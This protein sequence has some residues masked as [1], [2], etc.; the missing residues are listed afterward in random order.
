MTILFLVHSGVRYVWGTRGTAN[1][2]SLGGGAHKSESHVRFTK[3]TRA[4]C[5]RVGWGGQ[6]VAGGGLWVDIFWPLSE[7]D[8]RA[9]TTS[10]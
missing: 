4:V 5:R 1:R 10:A 8:H 7:W 9:I 6:F 3:G 2:L